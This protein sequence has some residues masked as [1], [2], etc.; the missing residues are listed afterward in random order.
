MDKTV[1]AALK[2]PLGIRNLTKGAIQHGET[3]A[4]NRERMAIPETA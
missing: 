2:Q 1:K 4:G 3:E